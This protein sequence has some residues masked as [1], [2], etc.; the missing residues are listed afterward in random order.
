MSTTSDIIAVFGET[1]DGLAA[2][3]VGDFAW[4]AI[5]CAEGFHIRAGWQV[6]K[7]MAEW[8]ADDM[9]SRERTVPDLAAF[10]ARVEDAAQH[11][12]ELRALKRRAGSG[13]ANTP[14]GRAQSAEIYGE[15]IAFFSTASHGG[16]KVQAAQ[17]ATMPAILRVRDGWYEED[18]EWAKVALAFPGLFTASERR[19][20]DATLRDWYPDC[21]EAL[22]GRALAPG[23]SHEKDR[24]RFET[25]HARDWIVISASRLD[26]APGT[27]RCI[28]ARGGDRDTIERR[29]YL[30][31]AHE[32]EPGRFGF[33]IDETRHQRCD[34][35]PGDAR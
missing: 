16:F 15:G 10:R 21:W 26:D 29:T 32:Y 34:G 3:L 2:G 18:C 14:W 17:L 31:P 4:L 9:W 25:E 1:A 30:V 24:G 19:S 20:A 28:A 7:P 22:H 12:R 33:V 8:T 27:V 13:G 35:E 11:R 5:P 6:S 23:E